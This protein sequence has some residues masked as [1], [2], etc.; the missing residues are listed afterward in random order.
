MDDGKM[1]QVGVRLPETLIGKIDREI[2]LEKKERPGTRITR[3]DV[4]RELLVHAL[5]ERQA[6]RER[7]E[8]EAKGKPRKKT[9]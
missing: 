8:R 6:F 9:G 1:V 7:A 3:A 5:D 2:E 4:M